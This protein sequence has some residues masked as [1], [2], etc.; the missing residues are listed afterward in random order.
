MQ[1]IVVWDP[2]GEFWEG[3][4]VDEARARQLEGRGTVMLPF[5]S[6]MFSMGG[7]GGFH[8]RAW[9]SGWA[10]PTGIPALFCPLTLR[11]AKELRALHWAARLVPATPAGPHAYDGHLRLAADGTQPGVAHAGYVPDAEA[12]T[13]DFRQLGAPDA[14]GGWVVRGRGLVSPS[15]DGYYG[16]GF[17][18]SGA[19]LKVAW[20]AISQAEALV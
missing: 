13:V 12:V 20:A 15:G 3:A 1:R 9:G 19:G 8:K 4:L 17:Y 16:F 2:E 6:R 5:V 14:H 10:L 11:G 7:V 18:G